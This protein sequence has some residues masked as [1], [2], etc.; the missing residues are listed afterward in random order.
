M[1]IT[2]R[3]PHPS[4][5]ALV[6]A[7][8]PGCGASHFFVAVTP[9]LSRITGAVGFAMQGDVAQV[10]DIRVIRTHRRQGIG[11]LL[12]AAVAETV[13]YRERMVCTV[14][15]L[16]SHEAAAFF[17]ARGFG[18]TQRLTVFEADVAL[19]NRHYQ[20]LFRRLYA[21]GKI[22]DSVGIVPLALAPL[23]QVM[24][25]YADH[26][27]A[28]SS[29]RP[30]R[31]IS[32]ISDP[33]YAP[34]LVLMAEGEAQGMMLLEFRGQTV[35][36]HARIIRPLWQKHS[37]GTVLFAEAVRT[38]FE[39][40]MTRALLES[41]DTNTTMSVARRHHM[42]PVAREDYYVTAKHGALI[43][44]SANSGPSR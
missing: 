41:F 24:R 23:D 42:E 39:Q 33:R 8:L 9:E 19:L 10:K 38:S 20:P 3:P 26:I 11:S 15:S 34:S 30:D 14:D 13:P 44:G 6:R 18:F 4:E 7:L 21:T 27:N 40:G 36:V 22:P 12:L 17:E 32:A 35:H 2:I 25:M 28:W 31:A 5:A 37:A 43:P 16:Q 1:H 29:I